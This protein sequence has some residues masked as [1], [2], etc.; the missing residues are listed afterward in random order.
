MRTDPDFKLLGESE[1]IVI[2]PRMISTVLMHML[3]EP[4]TRSGL[5]MM[6]Y[7]VNHPHMFRNAVDKGN[8]LRPSKVL[9]A[10]VLGFT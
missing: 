2:V 10:F 4:E 6:K 7:V 5:A 3:V 9:P 1:Y 8:K